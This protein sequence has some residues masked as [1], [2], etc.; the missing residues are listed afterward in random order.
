MQ[1]LVLFIIKIYTERVNYYVVPRS[2]LMTFK[3]SNFANSSLF[4]FLVNFLLFIYILGD[5]WCP[6]IQ[7]HLTLFLFFKKNKNK[8][9][10]HISWMKVELEIF[11]AITCPLVLPV[12]SRIGGGL[13]PGCQYLRDRERASERE[14]GASERDTE[15]EAE[16]QR[17]RKWKV[18]SR[19]PSRYGS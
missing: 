7:F 9:L 19:S 13:G 4:Y 3:K 5:F 1:S 6:S 18:K 8:K 17:D 15:R 14:T 2:Y 16:R 11:Y 12:P 10:L